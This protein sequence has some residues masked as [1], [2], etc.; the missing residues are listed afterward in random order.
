MN[1]DYAKSAKLLNEWTHKYPI[2]GNPIP[3][4][5]IPAELVLFGKTDE[6]ATQVA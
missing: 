2:R 3:Y 5:Y 6:A 4:V 1:G